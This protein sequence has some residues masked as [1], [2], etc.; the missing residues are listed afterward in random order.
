MLKDEFNN[1][2]CVS[3]CNIPKVYNFIEDK[4]KS[5]AYMTMEYFD[6]VSLN[7]F[8][9]DKGVLSEENSKYIISEVLIT[10]QYLHSIGI[11]HRD[12]KPENVLINESLKIKIIDFNIS[13]SFTSTPISEVNKFKS[14]FFTQICTPLYCAPELKEQLC[15]NEGID[16]WGAGTILFTILFGTFKA[17]SLNREKTVAQ[18]SLKMKEIISNQSDI[19]E[20]WKAFLFSLLENNSNERP[21]AIEALKSKWINGL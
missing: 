15:Y 6:G 12:I 11:C 18:R 9:S 4:A 17:N 19:C 10:I 1:L 16:I 20:E 14:I 13:K 5:E 21:T 3:N 8:I 2:K 7:Q